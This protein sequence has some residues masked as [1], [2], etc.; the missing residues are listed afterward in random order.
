MFTN[1]Y[2]HTHIRTYIYPYIHTYIHT[3]IYMY[4]HT[5]MHTHHSY[6]HTHIHAHTSYIHTYIHTYIYR[7]IKKSLVHLTITIQKV[8]SNFQIVPRT[9]PSRTVFSKTVC[10]IARSTFRMYTYSVMAIFKSS[11]LWEFFF[12]L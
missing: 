10:S 12:V 6:I 2:V 7:V 5:Y 8:T 11:N 3:N 9:S 4:I 1:S